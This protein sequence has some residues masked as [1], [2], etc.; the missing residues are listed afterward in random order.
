MRAVLL[1]IVLTLLVG[2]AAFTW[3][4][5]A[6]VVA[7]GIARSLATAGAITVTRPVSAKVLLGSEPHSAF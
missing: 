1:A 5:G 7:V 6:V 4:V 3:P 2:L